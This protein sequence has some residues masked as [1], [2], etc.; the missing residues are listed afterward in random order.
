[1]FQIYLKI[2]R[3]LEQQVPLTPNMEAN[4]VI[5][6]QNVLHAA[7]EQLKPTWREN[8]RILSQL[9]MFSQ[10]GKKNPS[11]SQISFCIENFM[12]QIVRTSLNSMFPFRHGNVTPLEAP[13]SE[14]SQSAHVQPPLPHCHVVT[15]LLQLIE[16]IDFQNFS[17][18][19]VVRYL[20]F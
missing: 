4:K 14:V 1:M 3:G 6:N 13:F 16:K 18:A 12:F 7:Q 2:Q 19:F 8:P 17:G 20:L 15:I 9:L 10:K 5:T 11:F